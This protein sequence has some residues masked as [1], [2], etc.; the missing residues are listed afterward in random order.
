M[1][2]ERKRGKRGGGEEEGGI[3]GFRKYFSSTVTHPVYH[4]GITRVYT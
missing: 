3:D 2:E 4:A 1:N